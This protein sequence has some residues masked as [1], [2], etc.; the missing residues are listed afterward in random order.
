MKK[1]LI[2]PAIVLGAAS[3][4]MS[5]VSL[6]ADTTTVTTSVATHPHPIS[7]L[8]KATGHLVYKVGE[9]AVN[10]VGAGLRG[11][12]RLFTGHTHHKTMTTE[13]MT[14]Q[15]VVSTQHHMST[16]RQ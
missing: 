15:P 3:L 7:D 13:P 2:L 1:L 8:F 9:G 6:A 10:I 4:M 5:G 11:T 14:A 12:G 16:T